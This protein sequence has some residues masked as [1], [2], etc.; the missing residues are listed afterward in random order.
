MDSGVKEPFWGVVRWS[1]RRQDKA[2]AAMPPQP[3]A[4]PLPLPL[5]QGAVFFNWTKDGIDASTPV[6]AQVLLYA[7]ATA[8]RAEAA[9]GGSCGRTRAIPGQAS[10]T[11]RRPCPSVCL[12]LLG[13][14]RPLKGGGWEFG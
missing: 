8:E 1:A 13:R 7:A 4:P 14:P 5:Q 10:R 2:A 6:P 12:A 11:L 9:E 3:P